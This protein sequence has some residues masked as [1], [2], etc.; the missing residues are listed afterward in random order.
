MKTTIQICLLITLFTFCSQSFAQ[1]LTGDVIRYKK[2]AHNLGGIGSIPTSSRLGASIYNI[3]D[4]NKDGIDD[5]AVGAHTYGYT[6]AIYILMLDTNGTVKSKK[7]LT[8]G[9]NGISGLNSTFGVS[10]TCLGDINDDGVNDIAVG[11]TGCSDGGSSNNGAIHIITLDTTGAATSQKK[12]SK[13]T[14]YQTGGLPLYN[15]SYFGVSIDTIGDLNNDGYNDLVVGAYY[16]AQ[17]TTRAGAVYILFMD[18]TYDVGSYQKI[19]GGVNNF[20]N[21]IAYKDHFGVSVSGIGDFDNDGVLD[22]AVGAFYDD[23]GIVDAGACYLIHLNTNGTVKNFTKLSNN[24][25]PNS[26]P[27]SGNSSNSLSRLPD[28]FGDGHPDIAIGAFRHNGDYGAVYILNIDSAENISNYKIINTPTIPNQ[29]YSRLGY[30][31]SHIGDYNNDG[32]VEIAISAGYESSNRGALYITSIKSELSITESIDNVSCYGGNDGS[33]KINVAGSNAP[34]TYLWN[35]GAYSDSIGS[36]SSGAY[37]VTVTNSIGGTSTKSYTISEP[38]DLIIASLGNLTICEGENTNIT[39]I[40]SGGTGPYTYNWSDG[41]PNQSNP[42]VSPQTTTTYTCFITDIQGCTSNNLNITVNV[43]PAPTAQFSGLNVA[44]CSSQPSVNLQGSPSGGTFTGPGM[45]G[46]TFDPSSANIGTNNIIY[47]YTDANGCVGRDTNSTQIIAAPDVQFSGISSAYCQNENAIDLTTKISPS[48]GSITINGNSSSSF[49]PSTLGTGTH[50][51]K[52]TVSDALGCSDT[53][54]LLVY[55]NPVTTTS[56][57]GL[58]SNYCENDNPA[59]ITTSPSGGVLSGNGVSGST[60]NPSTSGLGATTLSYTY[61]N[62]F[63]CTDTSSLSTNVYGITAINLS[64]PKTNYCNNETA[65]SISVSPTGGILSGPGVNNNN[66]TFDPTVAGI[67]N[68][69]I[70]YSYTNS[71]GCSNTQTQTVTV[72]TPATLSI[73]GLA[74]SYCSNHA[75]VNINASPTGGTLYGNGVNGTSFDPNVASVGTHVISYRY[76][77]GCIDTVE[78]TVTIHPQP[79]LN[80]T[81]A[82]NQVCENGMSIG[83]NATPSG[84]SFQGNGVTG[85]IFTPNQ[86]LIGQQ[87]IIYNYTD[88]NSCSNSDTNYITVNPSP[89]I[90]FAST[91]TLHCINDTDI[92]L[93][94][95]PSGGSFIG[96]GIIGNNFSASTA[97]IGTHTIQYSFT[98]ANNCSALDSIDVSVLSVANVTVAGYDS[99][100]CFNAIA[101]TLTPSISGGY[102]T[103]SNISNNV[104]IPSLLNSGIN[105]LEYKVM[106]SNGC[107]ATYQDS[108]LIHPPITMNAGNDTLL[109]CQHSPFQIGEVPSVGH[110]YH[111]IPSTGLSNPLIGNPTANPNS[112]IQYIVHKTELS[113]GCQD[114]DTITISTP[115]PIQLSISGDTNICFGDSLH[116]NA[117]GADYYNWSYGVTGSN[118]DFLPLLSHYIKVIATDTNGCSGSDSV[119]VSIN[120]IPHPNLGNDTFYY[121]NSVVT[122]NPG[123]FAEYLWFPTG[124]T[125]QTMSFIPDNLSSG[126]YSYG[127][128]VANQYGCWNSDTIT[129]MITTDIQDITPLANVKLYPNPSRD[130]IYLE[131]EQDLEKLEIYDLNGRL[132]R[133]IGMKGIPKKQISLS[134]LAKGSYIFRVYS[135]QQYKSILIQVQ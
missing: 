58:A 6:G 84:G 33:I 90:S 135:G 124:D 73:S 100:Y 22:I 27:F 93:S 11:E 50:K 63:G 15:S 101:D 98:D 49:T 12:I 30:D 32:E 10:V 67:G 34:F 99:A 53:D 120:P 118:F 38:N 19:Y 25:F 48:G 39:T 21:T 121:G 65:S 59:T 1:T 91:D 44:Y 79:T 89:M 107:F 8:Q 106:D 116:L 104:L 16:D 47:N 9:Q 55:I 133:S 102:F 87:T 110:I 94:V 43:N 127:V 14:G 3:G 26:N 54:S 92:M 69:T 97:G 81:I 24:S 108:I 105:L 68:K 17:T 129:F 85:S 122:L 29:Q 83:L 4:I 109:P 40:S 126:S 57:S 45:N 76:D 52:Y 23:D 56:L 88:F 82:N 31:I 2:I 130:Y 42:I 78:T 7:I 80:F 35:N 113:S 123:T 128:A 96:N 132:I 95:M 125:T 111:W 70:T 77:N 72:N 13:T 20:T 134:N 119:F 112:T 115:S 71:N 51:I 117:S 131:S 46:N 86:N 64:T 28:I 60:F 18:S 41:L 66:L 114:T 5:L 36:L 61:T 37:T 62:I 74:S 75:S 103:N